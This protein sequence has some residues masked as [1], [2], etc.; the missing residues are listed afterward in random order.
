MIEWTR[1]LEIVSSTPSRGNFFAFGKFLIA[2]NINIV[3]NVHPCLIYQKLSFSCEIKFEQK[4][5][6]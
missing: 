2:F 3:Q 4:L 6:I 5:D 1:G